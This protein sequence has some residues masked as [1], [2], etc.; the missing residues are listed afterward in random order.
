MAKWDSATDNS[1][2]E[3]KNATGASD[4]QINALRVQIAAWS[5]DN[6]NSRQ[7]FPFAPLRHRNA[8]VTA[9]TEGGWIKDISFGDN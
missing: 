9:K 3:L 7:A 2:L 1:M 6:P 4:G 5:E 8:T